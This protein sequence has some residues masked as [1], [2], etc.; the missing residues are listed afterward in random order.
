MTHYEYSIKTLG[1][2]EHGQSKCSAHDMTF[3]G[4]CLKCGYEPPMKL[5]GNMITIDMD[6][7]E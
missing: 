4:R 7:D 3:G 1:K 2:D 5:S 6:K